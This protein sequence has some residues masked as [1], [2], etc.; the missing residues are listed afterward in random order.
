MVLSS[1]GSPW[2]GTSMAGARE[3]AVDL[4]WGKEVIGN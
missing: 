4:L 1:W 3:T 2:L